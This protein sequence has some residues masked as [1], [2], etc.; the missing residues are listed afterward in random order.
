MN[1]DLHDLSD[2]RLIGLLRQGDAVVTR[3][4]IEEVA[5]RGT[6]VLPQLEA[7]LD[8]EALWD[9]DPPAM[10]APVHATF[11]LHAMGLPETVPLLIRAIRQS[12]EALLDWI[13]FESC[14]LFERVGPDCAEQLRAVYSDPEED[15]TTR[16][17][18]MEATLN[19]GFQRPEL[20]TTLIQDLAGFVQREESNEV[21]RNLLIQFHALGHADTVLR[22]LGTDH[23]P[24]WLNTD[25]PSLQDGVTLRDLYRPRAPLDLFYDPEEIARRQQDDEAFLAEDDATQT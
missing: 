1:E 13:A 14:V 11:A 18:L 7:I 19:L 4:V 20:H 2:E 5:R 10:W 25:D 12:V 17:Y 9:C 23:P 15:D 6:G 24:D 3:P 16:N 8:D 21:V 22:A